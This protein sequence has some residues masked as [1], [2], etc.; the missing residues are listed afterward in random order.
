MNL[1]QELERV[2]RLALTLDAE[3]RA[4][5]RHELDALDDANR[6]QILMAWAGDQK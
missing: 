4:E 1:Q 6:K 5:I 2:H 3:H